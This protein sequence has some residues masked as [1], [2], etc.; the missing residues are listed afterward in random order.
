MQRHAVRLLVLLAVGPVLACSDSSTPTSPPDPVGGYSAT[1][2]T[3][4]ANGVTVDQLAEGVTLT[5]TL[6]ADGSTGG[7]LF[8]PAAGQSPLDLTGTWTRKGT[9][10]TFHHPLQTFLDVLPFDLVDKQLTAEG[11]VGPNF[12]RVTLSR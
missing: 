3:T 8:V 4:T 12:I 10:V 1:E 2:F 5:L 9:T 6:A 11:Q 7:A